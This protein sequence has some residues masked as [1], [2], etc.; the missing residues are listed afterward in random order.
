MF[1]DHSATNGGNPLA[2]DCSD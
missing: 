1:F 2:A